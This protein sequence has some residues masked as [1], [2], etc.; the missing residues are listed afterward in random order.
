MLWTL[1][2]IH[3]IIPNWG[4]AIIFLTLIVRV[5]M[6]PLTKK[7]FLAMQAMQKIHPEL[8]RIQKLYANDKIRM[9]QEIMNMYRTKRAN[10]F[11]GIGL[12]ILQ[13]PIFFALYKTLLVALP[14][15]HA[16]FLWINDLSAM[17]TVFIMPVIMGLTMWVQAKFTHIKN[18]MTPGANIM[19]YLPFIFV[20]IFAWMPSGLV[21]Y[22]A[23]SNLAGIFQLW[24]MR[25]QSR[26]S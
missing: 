9:Q 20:G 19:K 11:A 14:L 3:D 10:P 15:R 8:Q 21:L 24:L 2:R 16:E 1:E 23:T 4:V 25:K 13:I 17:D 22:W 12:M 18:N 6:W 5:F 7:S 26:G